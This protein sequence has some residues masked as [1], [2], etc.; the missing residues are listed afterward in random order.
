MDG[1]HEPNAMKLYPRVD[2][3]HELVKRH[4]LTPSRSASEH[5]LNHHGQEKD[6][7]DYKQPCGCYAD[8]VDHVFTHGS[9]SCVRP[10]RRRPGFFIPL[11]IHSDPGIF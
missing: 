10:S 9:S 4:P 2:H 8:G 1:K 6:H 7:Q 11:S 3:A 5:P